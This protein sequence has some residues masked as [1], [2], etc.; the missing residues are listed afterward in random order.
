MKAM[1]AK[2]I[3]AILNKAIPKAESWSVGESYGANFHVKPLADVKKILFCVTPTHEVVEYFKQ[4]KYDLLIS[5]HPF[6]S[7]VPQLMYHT[8]LDCCKGGLNDMW[9]DFLGVKDATHFDRNLGWQGRIDP[10]SFHD[11][12]KKIENWLQHEIIGLSW[13]KKEIIESVCICTGLGGLV[14][15]EAERTGTDCYILGELTHTV[16]AGSTNFSSII[17]VGHTLTEN[18]GIAFIRSLLPSLQIDLAPLAIDYFGQETCSW[19]M[20]NQKRVSGDT[21]ILDDFDNFDIDNFDY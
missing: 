15:N 1:K 2:D 5:H 13:S 19:P 3:I 21:D 18:I 17:E 10:I 8:A 12:V 11:L 14:L 6:A 7:T 9:R 20:R 16:T 4:N